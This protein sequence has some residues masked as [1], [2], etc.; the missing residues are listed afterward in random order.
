[1]KN[2]EMSVQKNILTIKVD[3]SKSFGPS[4]SGKTTIIASTEGATSVPGSTDAAVRVGLN[5]YK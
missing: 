2:I 4:K 1:M 3:L 5:V